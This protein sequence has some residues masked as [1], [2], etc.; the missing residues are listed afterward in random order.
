MKYAKHY[1]L[2]TILALGAIT[3]CQET[4][5]KYRW[6]IYEDHLHKAYIHGSETDPLQSAQNL[7]KDINGTLETGDIVP[8]GQ[9]AHLGFLYYQANETNM[10]IDFLNKEKSD[11]PESTTFVD[12]LLKN[13]QAKP[14]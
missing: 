12:T 11:Y 3:G 9:Y 13:I 1:T 7:H 14:Q 8:P 6:G 10:A 5:P 4:A 2:I